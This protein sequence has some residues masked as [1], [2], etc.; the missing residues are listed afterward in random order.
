MKEKQVQFICSLCG[1]NLV[2]Y[3]DGHYACFCRER[4]EKKT[5][6]M[7]IYVAS[8]S[9]GCPVCLSSQLVLPFII[10]PPNTNSLIVCYNPKCSLYSIEEI[11]CSIYSLFFDGKM[12]C[13]VGKSGKEINIISPHPEIANKF[14]KQVAQYL[15]TNKVRIK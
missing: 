4:K 9:V 7:K 6:P 13:G 1:D 5:V 10:A 15:L 3:S 8:Q 11:E 2:E 14:F 12:I